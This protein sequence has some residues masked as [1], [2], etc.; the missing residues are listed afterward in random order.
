MSNTRSTTLFN[1]AGHV[2][3]VWE[4]EQ[5]HLVL[6]VIKAKMDEGVSFFVV[7]AEFTGNSISDKPLPGVSMITS[8]NAKQRA[9]AVQDDDFGKLVISGTVQVIK[10]DSTA[11]ETV[12]RATTAEEVVVAKTIAVRRARGG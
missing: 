12:K 9:V 4:K 3:L 10:D 11:T 5:D 8:D 1:K 2:T 6:P 7:K